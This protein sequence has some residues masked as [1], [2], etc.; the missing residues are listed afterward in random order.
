MDSLNRRGHWSYL[1][2]TWLLIWSILH[3]IF[4]K[5]IPSPYIGV[6]FSI[7]FTIFY[8]QII[9]PKSHIIMK[10]IIFLLHYISLCFSKYDLSIKSI[11]INIMVAI[12]YLMYITLNNKNSFE[13]YNKIGEKINKKYFN[14]TEIC[15]YLSV[16]FF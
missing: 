7:I 12:T 15:K 6:F 1:Y 13:I 14:Y 3:F 8:I 4:S 2:S 9:V 11:V 10:L 16:P 5:Y